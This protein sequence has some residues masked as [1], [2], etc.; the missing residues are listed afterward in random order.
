MSATVVVEEGASPAQFLFGESQGCYVVALTGTQQDLISK[1]KAAEV[2]I[3]R[4]GTVL[5]SEDVLMNLMVLTGQ[6]ED[7]TVHIRL[8]DLRA[9]HESFFPALM[10]GELG[11]G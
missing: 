4:L 5:G 9:A 1:A 11:V 3:N 10:Q 6:D 2:P 7:E 8:T